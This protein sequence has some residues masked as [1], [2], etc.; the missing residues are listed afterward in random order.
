MKRLALICFALPAALLAQDAAA[1]PK[2][3]GSID[4]GF[5]FNSDVRGSLDTYRSIVNLGEGPRVLGFH[6]TAYEAPRKAWDRLDISAAGWGGDP[7]AWFRL[8]ASKYSAYRLRLDH[9]DTAYFNA[10]PTFA[11]P[12]LDRGVFL[13]QRAF[14]T[15]RRLTDV[16]LDLLPGRRWQPYFGYTRDSGDGRGITGFNTGGNEYAVANTLDDR[17]HNFRGGV[18]FQGSKGHLTLEQGG[19][20]ISDD[21]VVSEAT[22]NPGNR[23]TGF[24]GRQLFLGNLLQTYNVTGSSIY[25]KVIA[26]LQPAS[27]IDLSG[28]FLYSQPKTDIVYNE[29]A[30][31]QFVDLNTLLFADQQSLRWIAASRQPHTAA[32]AVAEIRPFSRLRILESWFTDRFHTAS[33][34]D[35]LVWNQS[36][37]QA[38]LIVEAARWLT[39]RGGHRYTW[40]EGSNRAPALSQLAQESGRLRRNTWLAGVTLR[41]ISRITLCGD[42]ETAR[43]AEALFRTSLT[44][45]ER[46]RIRARFQVAQDLSLQF[47]FGYLDNENP[48]RLGSFSL[49]Q[50]QAAAAIQ[51]LPKGGN[52]FR[53]LAEYGRSSM[54]TDISYTVPQTFGRE[55][56]LYADNG[57]AITGL[58]DATLPVAKGWQP[59]LSA[60]GSAYFSSGS[61]P[62]NFYQ[63]QIRLALPVHKRMELLAEYR[64]FSFAQPLFRIEQFRTHQFL[65][66]IRLMH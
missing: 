15:R 34:F 49:R 54:R 10:M 50:R 42:M 25:S 19:L 13:N 56:S 2:S 43:T 17:T 60:G 46:A 35:R 59:K 38:E 9:R 65:A 4:L 24:L 41:P 48:P 45:Y 12:L 5:R 36:Q 1:E 6:Y 22:R 61:R 23:Q 8:D 39:L 30:R 64:W 33:T 53:L 40:G 57:H 55:R 28:N 18:N 51:W 47:N 66:G 3:G 20:L 7:A 44:D 52:R 37:Q 27:W 29:V 32:N 21:Q 31:G 16:S 63:P 11:N 58:I 14:D 62:S 26:G